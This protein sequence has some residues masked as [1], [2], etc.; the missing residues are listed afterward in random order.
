MPQDHDPKRI[1]PTGMTVMQVRLAQINRLERT[2]E[3]LSDAELQR[4][5]QELKDRLRS[6]K[7]AVG[8]P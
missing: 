4:K 3:N 6:K 5:T 8:G 1:K 7:A 2:M